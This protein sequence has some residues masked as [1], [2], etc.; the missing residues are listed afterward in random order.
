MYKE[1][2]GLREMPFNITPDPRFLYLSPNHLEALQHLRYGIREKKGFM[3]LTGE[4]G[5][6]KTTVCRYLLNELEGKAIETALILNPKLNETQLVQAILQELGVE[7]LEKSRQGML[8]QLNAHLLNLVHQQKEILVIIDEAQNMSMAALEFLRLLSNLETDQQK[9]MQILLIG[10]P[11]LKDKLNHRDLRQLKQ[12]VLVHYDLQPLS[13]D[14][15]M[16]YVR[17]RLILA[18]ANGRPD[19]TDRALRKI[20]RVTGGVPRLV[21]HL[22]DKAILSAFIKS[23]DRVNWWDVR[24]A[25]REISRL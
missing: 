18:G 9:L 6:G 20:Y 22:C 3:V 23:R 4:V 11:E 2:Y 7:K 12:R 25:A 1:F 21:N 8:Q 16:Q 10:Q 17:Y 19:F 24:R 15:L 5:C 13:M 14:Q